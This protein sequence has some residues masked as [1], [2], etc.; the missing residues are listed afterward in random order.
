MRVPDVDNGLTSVG[1][2][3][4]SNALR[5]ERNREK[6]RNAGRIGKIERK[7]WKMEE[8]IYDNIVVERRKNA[9]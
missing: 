1:R 8:K 9:E 2:I 3:N 5:S 4:L 6:Y 7:K